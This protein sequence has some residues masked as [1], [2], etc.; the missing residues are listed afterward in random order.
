MFFQVF[1]EAGRKTDTGIRGRILDDNNG[2]IQGV[3][4]TAYSTSNMKRLPDFVSTLT[5]DDGF[6]VL[7]LPVGGKW[8][9]G[10]RSHA[11]GVPKPGE[12]VVKYE[13]LKDNSIQVP[14]GSFFNGVDITLRPF[15]SRPPAGYKPY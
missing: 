11:R 2:P 7:Y 14:E 10:A 13:G 4:T 3:F 9:V 5:W 1:T 15:S 8:Y 12:P 6:F